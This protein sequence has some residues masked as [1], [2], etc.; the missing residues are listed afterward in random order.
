MLSPNLPQAGSLINRGSL[1][2]LP[3]FRSKGKKAATSADADG[4][5]TLKTKE[6][7]VL[8][9]SG[10]GFLPKQVT[11]TGTEQITISVSRKESSM[12]EV[13]I[14]PALWAYSARRRSWDV[15]H[16]QGLRQGYYPGRADQCH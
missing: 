10:A 12:A 5:F 6:G 2:L 8:I 15:F 3:L 1:Y 9:V 4:Y 11:V 14:T 7:D 16:C 13:V